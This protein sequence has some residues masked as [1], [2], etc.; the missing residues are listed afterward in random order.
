MPVSY[1]KRVV[2]EKT[3]EIWNDRWL[4]VTTGSATRKFIPTVKDRAKMKSYFRP[5]FY[6]SQ[7]LTNHGKFNEYL[8]QFKLKN[9][10]FCSNCQTSIE[11]AD[12]LIFNCHRYEQQRE[13][14]KQQIQAKKIQWP[15]IHS[16]LI[17][18]DIF[19]YFN[20]FCENVLNL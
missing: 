11:N 7:F 15:C 10:S 5:N 2:Y 17:S 6:L 8:T 16:T 14:L 3:I 1:V 4:S 18:K 19:I 13:E 20:N 9:D 12:H